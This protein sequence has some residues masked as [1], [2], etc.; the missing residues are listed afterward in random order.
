MRDKNLK[1]RSVEITRHGGPEVL[2]LV[3]TPSPVLE[4]PDGIRIAVA[5]CGVNFADVMMRMGLYPEAPKPPF[6]PGYEIAGTVT[7][8]G[9]QVS[10]FRPGERVLAG[11]VFGGYSSEVIVPEHQARKTPA[12]LSDLEAAAIPVNFLTAWIAL[13]EMARVREGDRVLIQSAAG[14][15][16]TAATQIARNA[17]ARV[18]GLVGSEAKRA[19]VLELGATECLLS[20]DWETMSDFEAVRD[21]AFDVILDNEG[22]RS[23]ARNF[24]RLAPSGRVIHSGVSGMVGGRRKSLIHALLHLVRTPLLH[25]LKLTSENKG[26]FGLNLLHLFGPEHDSLIQRAFDRVLAEVAAGRLKPVIGKTFALSE[27]GAAHD[28][29]QSRGN[30]GKVILIPG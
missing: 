3:E 2:K 27:T 28:W 12:A 9:E 19:R 22:G 10:R 6:V 7:E 29:L 1:I 5:A 15:V 18:T 17:G 21:G 4:R 20:A 11:T 25:P 13:Q 30:T 16:G 23:L 14:G 26:V 8:V 24:N